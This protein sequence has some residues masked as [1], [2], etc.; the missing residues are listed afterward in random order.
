M[1]CNNTP[2]IKYSLQDGGIVVTLATTGKDGL[3]SPQNGLTFREEGQET[4]LGGW[5]KPV[6]VT[7]RLE[8]GLSEIC[9]VQ[10]A[11]EAV[12]ALAVAEQ[13]KQAVD[14]LSAAIEKGLSV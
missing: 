9:F 5:Y 12:R 4:A 6:S 14:E 7:D 1:T 13:A 2:C 10:A 3:L 11:D 8:S